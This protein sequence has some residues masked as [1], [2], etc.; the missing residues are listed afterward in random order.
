MSN[1]AIKEEIIIALHLERWHEWVYRLPK[2]Y[3]RMPQN[4]YQSMVLH[5][6]GRL[7][8][9]A[10]VSVFYAGTNFFEALRVVFDFKKVA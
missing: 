10:A 1:E 5:S 4:I 7:R 8:G 6:K 3:G 9:P 2:K